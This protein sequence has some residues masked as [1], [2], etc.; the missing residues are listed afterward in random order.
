[1]RSSKVG[2]YKI[3]YE[4]GEEFRILK[5]EVFSRNDYYVELESDKPV[6]VDAGAYIG[7]TVLYFKQLYPQARVIA[8]EPYPQSFALLKRN[9]EENQLTEV[10]LVQAALAPRAGEVTLHA[11]I[12]G[13]DWFTT[14]SYLQSGWDKRQTTE[15]VMVRGVTLAEIALGRIDLLKMDIEG[16]ELPVLKSLVGEF[17][18]IHNIIV[19]VHPIGG[20]LP[21]ELFKILEQAGYRI[22]VRVEGKMTKEREKVTELAIVT[23]TRK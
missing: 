12:S 14:V 16:M 3:W 10:V 8:L 5:R 9:V 22:E 7:D 20:K 23:A 13:H 21:K 11:D 1:M 19:E 15:A 18:R 2:K 4:N 6:I 17:S